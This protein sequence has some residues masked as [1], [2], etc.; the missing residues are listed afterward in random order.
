MERGVA[1]SY[2]IPGDKNK[3]L[4]ASCAQKSR[5]PRGGQGLVRGPAVVQPARTLLQQE[6]AAER[7]R[8]SAI[9]ERR[10]EGNRGNDSAL[11]APYALAALNS[12]ST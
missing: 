12:I 3:V 9:G 10:E 2:P 6:L 4:A 7:D 1:E 8:G 11:A 5:A